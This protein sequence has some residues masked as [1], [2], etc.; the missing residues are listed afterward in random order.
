MTH[1]IYLKSHLLLH[2][3]PDITTTEA[4]CMWSCYF[5]TQYALESLLHIELTSKQDT[6]LLHLN[7]PERCY[8]SFR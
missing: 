7:S 6:P 1:T 8:A 2:I 5:N 3:N 4:D